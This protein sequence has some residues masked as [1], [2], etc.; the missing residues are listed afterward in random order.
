MRQL[1]SGVLVKAALAVT[2]AGTSEIDGSTIDTA[3]YEGVMFIA[4]F[5]TAAANN[6]L[7]AQQDSASDMST[8]ADLEGSSVGVGASDEIVWLDIYRPRER[9]VRVQAERGTSTTLEWGV[10]LLYGAKNQPVD[11]TVAGT[12]H[13]ETLISPAEG[14]A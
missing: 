1:S 2:T 14:T 10:A 4:K 13:G 8:A 6:T 5:G 7:Q 12:I 3:G 9:Y 11:N